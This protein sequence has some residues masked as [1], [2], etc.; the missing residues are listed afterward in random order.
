MRFVHRTL[1]IPLLLAAIAAGGC[2]AVPMRPAPAPAPAPAQAPERV[3]TPNPGVNV[4]GSALGNP[5][6]GRYP[7][8]RAGSAYD[9]PSTGVATIASAVPGAGPINA[10]VLGNVAIIGLQTG[11]RNIHHR[12]SQQIQS[13]FPHVVEVRFTQDPTQIRRIAEAGQLIRTQR[14]IGALLPELG[15]MGSG[16]PAVQ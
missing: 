16:L 3:S 14:S 2:T 11:D 9:D 4:Q 15:T 10:V 12:I 7:H 13:S 8:P 6:A 5:E 1:M